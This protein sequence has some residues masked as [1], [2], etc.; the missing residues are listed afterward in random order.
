MRT[1][2]F[3]VALLCGALL[4]AFI[5]PAAAQADF[6][7]HA[8]SVES[9]KQGGEV[10]LQAGSH[11]FDFK[12][13]VQMNQDAEGFPEGTLRQ[14]VVNLPPG[15]VGNPQAVPRCPI[16]QFAGEAAHCRG[17]TQVGV[18]KIDLKAGSEVRE[19]ESPVF[20]LEP[21]AGVAASIGFSA[22]E[23]NS[24][25]EG[26]LRSGSDYGISV[27]DVTIP[28]KL[29]IQSI[30]E[31]IW[32]VPAESAHDEERTCF[33]D[34]FGNKEEGC[35]SDLT[36]EPFFTLPTSC[37][38]PLA[39]TV[40]VSSVQE[41]LATE[42]QTAYL[43]NE[44][45]QPEALHGCDRPPFA[46]TIEA[47]PET[48]SAE[49]PTGLNVNLKVPQQKGMEGLA[50]AN[51]KGTTV[52]L[53][54]GL[55]VNPSAATGLGACSLAQIDL[56]GPGPATCPANS[57]LGTVAIETP[58][59][60]HPLQGTVYLARQGENPFG[61]FI[62]LYIA[63][64]DPLSGVVVKLAGE[65]QPNPVTGQLTATFA[66]NP[67]LPFENLNV[68][69]NGG[70]R[71]SLT[72]PST[73]GTY[74]T[75]TALV[76]WTYPE[77]AIAHPS[78]PF[79]ISAAP[80]GGPCAASESQMPKSFAFEAGNATPLAGTYSP[81]VLKLSRENGSQRLSGLN[82][83]LPLGL[84]GRLAGTAECSD[85]QIA[86]ASGRSG[87]G[88]GAL[89]RQSPSC[90]ANSEIGTVTVGVGSGSPFF[91]Q[92]HVY[93]AGPYKGA[94]LSTAIIAPAVAGPFDLGVVVVRAA[95]FVNFETAQ[96]TA[97]SDPLPT[98]LQGVPLDIR[99]V[100]LKID[101]SQFTL[102][103]TNCGV[104]A[105]TAEAITAAGQSAPLSNR[106]QV[107]GCG[108]LGFAPKLS[109]HLKGQT[110]R[111]GH[112]ALK[113]VLTYPQGSSY[114]NI[115]RVQ[116]GL[117]HSEFLDQGN[118]DKVCTR[119]QLN[120]ATCPKRSIYGHAKAWTPLLDRPIEG[121][122]Y[123]GVGFGYKLPAL[124][125]DLNGQVRL[126]LKGKVDTT[127]GGGIRSTFEAVPDA[128]VSRFIL[129]MKGGKKYG[130]LENSENICR[131]P[132]RAS[133]RFV[134]QNNK[135]AQLQPLIANSCSKGSGQSSQHRPR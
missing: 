15:M 62:A 98:I 130:L 78:D 64:F 116:V 10:D 123:L 111:S 43:V 2:R 110:K 38:G 66:E 129:E 127:K 29:N 31:T 50:T 134:A 112:P 18:V 105:L 20:N 36:P 71:A 25:Q 23:Y 70:P 100:A 42:S 132:Q 57:Q 13:D 106:F 5:A 6:G 45:G 40:T 125:A 16:T 104:K 1:A 83:T 86:Q 133:A 79:E 93:L 46:P 51:L 120:S 114:A 61:A 73:C 87:P 41:P 91:A 122:V 135:V 22:A 96:I 126:L 14:L 47:R 118:L 19:V 49:S 54:A 103:P 75:T 108:G 11:P 90:P 27:S 121:P 88:Q 17:V 59:L 94:P 101:R 33:I 44:E 58:L 12:V 128:P 119:P 32:G 115:A 85:A 4:V 76:P 37:A 39:T 102:N 124:V 69:F 26:S 55:A 67:Q 24:Y 99:S 60:D 72:T 65:V 48:S 82:L 131:K 80:G 84:T 107:G 28:T 109:L 9:V 34:E 53:P 3:A 77:G 7:V 117:P 89:E 21:P 113:A 68:S 56:H 97:K 81:F 8:L 74:T 30:T 92:G 52:T 63:V 95:L 35:R